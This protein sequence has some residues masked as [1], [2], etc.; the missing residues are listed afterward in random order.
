MLRIC[1][2]SMSRNK[3][4]IEIRLSLAINKKHTLKL[5]H[6]FP[7]HPFPT[8]WKHQETLRFSDFFQGV[9]KGCIGNKWVNSISHVRYPTQRMQLGTW[10]NKLLGWGVLQIFE[11]LL[12]IF[13]SIL[14]VCH[15]SEY[16]SVVDRN[17]PLHRVRALSMLIHIQV[18]ILW[19]P[20][21]IFWHHLEFI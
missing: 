4:N 10:K 8:P 1:H 12:T 2:N 7:M 9:E 13:Y 6:F 14:D 20:V 19:C 21:Y 5:T 16:A 15:G 18:W 3:T 17:L 11:K